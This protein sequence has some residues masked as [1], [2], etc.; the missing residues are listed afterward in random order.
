LFP[1]N[2]KEGERINRLTNGGSQSEQ[3]SELHWQSKRKQNKG[4]S[5]KSVQK[6]HHES[7]RDTNEV[8]AGQTLKVDHSTC[9]SSYRPPSKCRLFDYFHADKLVKLELKL[10][11]AC[12]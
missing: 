9:C 7:D 5:I 6:D 8:D 4:K 2:Q 1:C 10:V 11:F 12:E 3:I